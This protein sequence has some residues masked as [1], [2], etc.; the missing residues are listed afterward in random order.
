MKDRRQH[1]VAADCS[2]TAIENSRTRCTKIQMIIATI[3]GTS[4]GRM[5]RLKVCNK[6]R[7]RRRPPRGRR[8]SEQARLHHARGHRQEG[9]HVPDRDPARPCRRAEGNAAEGYEDQRDT[10]HPGA[11]RQE[12]HGEDIEHP[13]STQLRPE[14][15]Q[16]WP[17]RQDEAPAA[18]MEINTAFIEASRNLAG[19]EIGIGDKGRPLQHRQ[20]EPHRSK[21]MRLAQSSAM[22]ATGLQ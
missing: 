7:R 9:N 11:A 19:E 10:D 5:T 8:W 17:M 4:S 20:A 18:V 22:R 13:G 1:A 6:V 12:N 2:M 3:V 15:D 16:T 14:H 21:G